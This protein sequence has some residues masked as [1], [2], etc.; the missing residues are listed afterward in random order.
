ML[1]ALSMS[2]HEFCMTYLN[3]AESELI[4]GLLDSMRF[5]FGMFRKLSFS[6]MRAFFAAHRG[7]SLSE[8]AQAIEGHGAQFLL[9]QACLWL[10]T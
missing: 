10:T 1:K 8:G 4:P 5:I 7:E 3:L 2:V 6:F 9:F